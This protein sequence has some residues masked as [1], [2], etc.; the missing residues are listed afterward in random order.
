MSKHDE[1]PYYRLIPVLDGDATPGQHVPFR[2]HR[3][4]KRDAQRNL[5]D[6][7][8]DGDTLVTF[9]ADAIATTYQLGL[10]LDRQLRRAGYDVDESDNPDPTGI[11]P[12]AF[13]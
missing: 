13:Q 4:V 10:G 1:N 12:T 5:W 2:N 9:D 3:V 7:R 11:E 8:V 6:L